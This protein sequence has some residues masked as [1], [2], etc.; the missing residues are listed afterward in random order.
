VNELKNKALKEYVDTVL[1]MLEE[2][3]NPWEKP[4]RH[5]YNPTTDKE[6][7]GLNRLFLDIQ[8]H[9]DP[10]YMTYLQAQTAGYQV[11]RGAK[12][13]HLQ[14]FSFYDKKEKKQ[15]SIKEAWDP[16]RMQDI[17]PMRKSF[18]VFNAKDIE[19]IEPHKETQQKT[20]EEIAVLE[21]VERC[22]ERLNITMNRGGSRAFY[23]P[24]FDRLNVPAE[25]NF[26]SNK[27][28][29]STLLHELTH[30]T[31]HPSRLNRL[32]NLTGRDDPAY[33]KEELVAELGTLFLKREFGI[34]V[35]TPDS[36]SI[37]YLH[38]WHQRIKDN[39]SYLFDAI[40]QAE[41]AT[42]YLLE[43]GLEK[44]IQPVVIYHD[45]RLTPRESV[46][47][48]LTVSTND[49]ELV[50]SM[51]EMM[52]SR[53]TANR[54]RER[55]ERATTISREVIL[56]A[57]ELPFRSHDNVGFRVLDQMKDNPLEP[58]VDPVSLGI[59]LEKQAI[60]IRQSEQDREYEHD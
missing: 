40:K 24:A 44:E 59:A 6:Y 29:L 48:I 39:P 10:R 42:E 50:R 49:Q 57:T 23:Q 14:Y 22:T 58:Y 53:A 17:V 55:L 16:E 20:T 46:E 19:N 34:D 18:T 1:Q 41:Q 28:E 27:E 9:E 3:Q 12:G 2:N 11:K 15:V 13:I 54:Y 56:K 25:M 60:A 51:D 38:T 47:A 36:N 52:P 26:T 37:A 31:G 33:A 45:N 7:R 43:I 30:A 35:A 21:F 32:D 5:A 4:W 8:K